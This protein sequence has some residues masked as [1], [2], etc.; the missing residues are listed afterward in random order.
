MYERATWAVLEA[1]AAALS[2]LLDI[3]GQIVDHE[4]S[5]LERE[6]VELEERSNGL[7]ASQAALR[8]ADARS[9]GI[10]EGSLDGI[11]GIDSAG[12][13]LDFNHAAEE[14]F[15][16]TREDVIGE[17]LSDVIIPYSMRERHQQGIARF[18]AT[19]TGPILGRRIEV[20]ALRRDGTEFPVE[21]IVTQV[22]DADPPLF[23]GYVRDLSVARRAAAELRSGQERLAHIARTLQA[24]LLPPTLP[25]IEG[26]DIAAAF[27]S[28]GDG[29][30]VGGDFYDAFELKNGRWALV[31]GDVCGKGSDAAAL[32]ALARHTLRAAGM[33]SN[34]PANVLDALN[35]AIYRQ[36]GER[37]CT[38]I[39]AMFEPRSGIVELA[40]GGH[41]LP[42][43]LR[44]TGEVEQVGIGG[45]LLGPFEQWRGATDRLE[46][47]H[48]DTLIFYSDGAT[49]A[50]SGKEFFGEDRLATAIGSTSG[51]DVAAAVD[52]LEETVLRF[53]GSLT[54][55]LA[56]L[57]MRRR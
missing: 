20:N 2:Q 5:R 7:E 33:R 47:H 43:V 1:R 10:I 54:D 8:V 37:F 53:A 39:Y 11:I 16:Q 28:L 31:L 17:L 27:R 6:A 9:T 14:M 41:P 32:T 24:S 57:A 38:A 42:F 36:G 4:S 40:V 50:R 26:A 21:L 48:G 34:D 12:R 18:L 13:I 45:T 29:Y 55:D 25:E 49:E 22:R 30:E 19:G 3:R 51:L 15:E 44:S 46:V 23:N 52:S 56:I 35:E